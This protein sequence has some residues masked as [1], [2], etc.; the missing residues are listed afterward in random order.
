MTDEELRRFCV[1]QAVL[2]INKADT[3]HYLRGFMGGPEI[4]LYS[5]TELADYL[6]EYIKSGTSKSL[7]K[8][9]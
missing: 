5:P 8:V 6:F 9:I 2:L 7:E 4:S 3:K 1:E